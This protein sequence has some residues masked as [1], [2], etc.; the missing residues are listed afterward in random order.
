MRR[1][2]GDT[3]R[4]A[5]KR[6][7]TVDR[8]LGPGARSEARRQRDRRGGAPWHF[9]LVVVMATVYLGWRAVEGVV[10]LVEWIV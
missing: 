10:W 6:A 8:R 4:P 7:G 9:W 1:R 3:G 5:R 2:S